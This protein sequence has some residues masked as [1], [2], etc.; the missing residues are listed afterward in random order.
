[1]METEKIK[2]VLPT[3]FTPKVQHAF[4]EALKFTARNAAIEIHLAHVATDDDVLEEDVQNSF[5]AM[6]RAAGANVEDSSIFTHFV[7][8]DKKEIIQGIAEIV[9]V[10]NP[11][12][13]V[14]GYELKKGLSRFI[15][16]SLFKVFESTT[17][18]IFAIKEGESL[19]DLNEIMF[20]LDLHKLSRQKLFT[21]I[22]LAKLINSEIQLVSVAANYTERDHTQLKIVTKQV[23]EEMNKSEVKFSQHY[24]EGE[25]FKDL[26]ADFAENNGSDMIA[27]V[28]NSD[29]TFMDRVWGSEDEAILAHTS[30]PLFIVHS[31]M[32]T[33]MEWGYSTPV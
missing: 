20:P 11:N 24:M 33:V 16:P 28:F 14:L 13:I 1:M 18:P 31:R 30:I 12:Y 4:N 9:E 3:D 22:H 26:V 29:D 10:I 19:G 27:R 5:E 7:R 6:I 2:L 17:C 15:G 23:V 32:K 21:T 25:S 8:K